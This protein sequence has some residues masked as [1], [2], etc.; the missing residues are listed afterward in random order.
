MPP[1]ADPAAD[2]LPHEIAGPVWYL[3]YPLP[4]MVGA[5]LV[6][7]ALLLLAVWLFVRWRRRRGRR[8]LTAREKALAALTDAQARA[9]GA[10]PYEFSIEVCDVLRSFLGTEH[11]LPA[12]TQTSYEFLQ[13]ARNSG[14]FNTDRIARLTRF[15]D[16]ADAIKFARADATGQD[17]AELVALAEDLVKGEVS[18]AV[19]A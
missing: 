7:L 17:N 2:L 9:Q 4:V 16:K 6:L 3:P 13:T 12:T 5:A 15:L 10:S 11:H 14:I 1:T 18:D 8:I 19:A